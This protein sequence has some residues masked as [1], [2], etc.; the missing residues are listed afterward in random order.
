M[1]RRY[2]AFIT[3]SLISSLGATRETWQTKTLS[4]PFG[5]RERWLFVVPPTFRAARRLLA[6]AIVAR[7]WSADNGA[8]AA[9]WQAGS[10]ASLIGA[11]LA[12]GLRAARSL[13][14][15]S[16]P[17]AI[18]L[19][20]GRYVTRPA[21]RFGSYSIARGA[22]SPQ[23]MALRMR[24]V[25]KSSSRR[26]QAVETAPHGGCGRHKTRLRGGPRAP[27]AG[28]RRRTWWAVRPFRRAF[29]RQPATA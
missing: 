3:S 27:P 21:L 1:G 13:L 20:Q 29:I 14:N 9:V 15:G 10:G 22:L 2:D 23:A 4:H 17:A 16:Q 26:E 28:P 24:T 25:S 6:G 18:L 19:C 12:G 7:F 5:T 11:G 8:T